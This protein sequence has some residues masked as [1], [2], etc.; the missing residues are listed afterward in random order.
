T[1]DLARTRPKAVVLYDAP[2]L[3]EAGAHRRMDR[4]I[5]VTAD[6][7]TQIARLQRRNGLSRAEALRRIR[8]QMPL[9]DKVKLADYVIDGTLP[10]SYVRRH[11]RR[12]YQELKTLD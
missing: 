6:Q 5:V 1:R 11:V 4:L 2:G 9:R 7:A 3:I 8:A 12:L 10:L